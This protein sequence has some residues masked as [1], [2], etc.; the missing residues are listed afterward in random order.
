[1]IAFRI[2][3]VIRRTAGMRLKKQGGNGYFRSATR[4]IIESGLL[5]T[6]STA[7]LFGVAITQSPLVYPLAD[8]V[9]TPPLPCVFNELSLLTLR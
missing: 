5:Y 6:A 1:M 4:I 8:C 3:V 9:R 7:V 2:I